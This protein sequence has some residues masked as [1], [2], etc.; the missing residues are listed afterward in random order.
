MMITQI[1][2]C[3]LLAIANKF[4]SVQLQVRLFQA[5][6]NS[7]SY[8]ARNF[9]GQATESVSGGLLVNLTPLFHLQPLCAPYRDT[10]MLCVMIKWERRT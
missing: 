6:R 7:F 2:K 4:S 9:P 10:K 5:K 8:R 3:S 1:Q